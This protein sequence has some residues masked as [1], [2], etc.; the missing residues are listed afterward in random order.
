MIG[1]LERSV[2]RVLPAKHQTL[3][4]MRVIT[5][6][7]LSLEQLQALTQIEQLDAELGRRN[8]LGP[9]TRKGSH[10]RRSQLLRVGIALLETASMGWAFPSIRLI[11]RRGR[12]ESQGRPCTNRRP[13]GRSETCRTGINGNPSVAGFPP[14]PTLPARRSS[15]HLCVTTPLAAHDK[16]SD[17]PRSLSSALF[18][19]LRLEDRRFSGRSKTR[20]WPGLEQALGDWNMGRFAGLPCFDRWLAAVEKEQVWLSWRPSAIFFAHQPWIRRRIFTRR[21]SD[22]GEGWT[23]FLRKTSQT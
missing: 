9:G 6:W 7:L 5:Q 23:P 20:S 8:F 18:A 21:V 2:H 4:P 16:K 22:P 3:W 10:R 19:W 17:L 12:F 14:H 13:C 15:N 1:L 11:E